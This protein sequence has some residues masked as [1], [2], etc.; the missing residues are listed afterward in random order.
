MIPSHKYAV[1]V[2]S[3]VVAVMPVPVAVAGLEEELAALRH[4]VGEIKR[5]LAELKA[6]QQRNASLRGEPTRTSVRV[7]GRPTLGLSAAPI[8][9]VEFSDYQ[10]S[11][12]RR[13]AESTFPLLKTTFIDT[14]KVQ[15]VVRD[16]PLPIHPQAAK[17]A[18]A[19]LCA[20]E[21]GQYWAMH[22]LLFKHQH[23]LSVSV[24][25]RLA[26]SAG[27]ETEQFARC[28]DNDRFGSEVKK[29]VAEAQT[30][31]VRGTPTFFIGRTTP[32]GTIFGSRLVGA[33]PFDAFKQMIERELGSIAAPS[34]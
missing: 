11:F 23:D 9:V 20:G 28:L 34:P 30:A 26:Q 18:E 6:L 17:A 3:L 21:Q 14:G 19:A 32:H 2:L 29:E 15:Y 1:L 22:G 12:C 13:Y 16:L 33:Q 5:E 31:G 7:R 4:E 25:K 8:T 10:C 24:L 27:L